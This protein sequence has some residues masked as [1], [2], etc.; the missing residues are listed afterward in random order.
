MELKFEEKFPA[1]RWA[2]Y[3]SEAWLCALRAAVA[4]GTQSHICFSQLKL[5]VCKGLAFQQ[6][7][8]IDK[9]FNNHTKTVSES[10]NC[11]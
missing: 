11:S 8:R 2:G 1:D 3:S 5:K 4:M 6:R 9:T 10:Q 7:S